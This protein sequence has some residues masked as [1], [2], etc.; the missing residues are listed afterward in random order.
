MSANLHCV[1]R[2]NLSAFVA[3][4]ASVG[5]R[6]PELSLVA[7][8]IL[9]DTLETPR[10]LTGRQEANSSDS[11]QQ[12]PIIADLLLAAMQWFLYCDD[13]IEILCLLAKDFESIS[14]T[15]ESTERAN[16]TPNSGFSVAR[17]GF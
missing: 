14:E 1:E 3:R 12:L 10:P 9:R 8:W 15:G 16:V 17:W 7:I 4:L 5:V 11:E 6:D 2:Q 13:N